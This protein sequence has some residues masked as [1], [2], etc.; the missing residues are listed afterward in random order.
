MITK[1]CKNCK[2]KFST[3]PCRVGN[4][5]SRSCCS[6]Q[7]KTHFIKG[8]KWVGI[9]RTNGIRQ[10]PLG[11]ISL[12]SPNHPYRNVRNEVL[13]HR[14][15][16]EKHLKRYLKPNEVV[17]HK[18]GNKKDNRIKNL[19]LFSD[20]SKHMKYEYK[21]SSKFRKTAKIGQFKKKIK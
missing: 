21:T 2:S 16:M 15:V 1:I 12:Y 4:Y 10:H 3:F 14:L 6:K 17:H 8:H 20:Q 11:Y 5:C 19:K 7:A 18:N 13:K 9:F